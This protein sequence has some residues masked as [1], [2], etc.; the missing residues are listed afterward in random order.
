VVGGAN[1][2]LIEA[3]DI[4]RFAVSWMGERFAGG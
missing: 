4:V 1:A 2:E 3:A